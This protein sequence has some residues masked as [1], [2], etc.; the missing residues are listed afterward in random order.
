MELHIQFASDVNFHF[1]AWF[2]LA[3]A[4]KKPLQ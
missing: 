1:S 2:A 4:I 3:L